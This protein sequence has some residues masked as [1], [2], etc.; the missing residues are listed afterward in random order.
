M[1]TDLV[2]SST[3]DSDYAIL[4]NANI[5]SLPFDIDQQM[6]FLSHVID[7]QKEDIF[8]QVKDKIKAEW[9]A[10]AYAARLYQC[11]VDFYDKYNHIPASR[12]ELAASIRHMDAGERLRVLNAEIACREKKHL[13]SP[14][15]M[16]SDLTQ[17]MRFV[18][19]LNAG[20]D[21][22][23]LFNQKNLAG[24]FKVLEG[25]VKEYQ[26]ISFSGNSIT[27]IDD[28]RSIITRRKE[29]NTDAL[30]TGFT[31]L[32]KKLNPDGVSGSLVKKESSLLLAS[33]NAG[34]STVMCTVA[35]HN[36]LRGKN[37][38]WYTL[39][40]NKDAL[41]EMMWCS[42]FQATRSEFRQLEYSSDEK[43]IQALNGIGGHLKR[44]LVH[45]HAQKEGHLVQ[46]VI[47]D[48]R[49]HLIH[50]KATQGRSTDLVIVD[51]PGVLN[52]G[53]RGNIK[54]E[55]R[56]AQKDIYR[57]FFDLAGEE[58]FHLLTAVQANR[59]AEKE[60]KG[61]SYGKKSTSRLIT[62]ADIS[63]SWGIAQDAPMVFTLNRNDEDMANNVLHFNID[64]SRNGETG[65]VVSCKTDF[66]RCRT[67]SDELGGFAYRGTDSFSKK[68]LSILES[69]KNQEL[70]SSILNDILSEK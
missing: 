17:W 40:G 43:K 58:N 54:M 48:I 8:M 61:Y 15:V 67:H 29:Q 13:Y 57:S 65:W 56:Q 5:T 66:A 47:S 63:E 37:V 22:A 33:T 10:D 12:D 34:K 25:A 46:D 39:E 2:K 4:K 62:K 70:T 14:D 64:K 18:V 53:G 19:M 23:N 50:F 45:V 51:Y 32:D 42:I 24:A 26:T 68:T 9:F 31:L 16:M 41:M 3:T 1:N 44:H 49:N 11:Y 6:A 55:Y 60:S 52:M 38:L 20:Q 36:L 28:W 21:S 35:M 59:A 7:F 30:S 27:P 69:Y